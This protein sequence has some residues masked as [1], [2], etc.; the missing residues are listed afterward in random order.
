MLKFLLSCFMPFLSNSMY[1]TFV[2]HLMQFSSVND[3]KKST[4]STTTDLVAAEKESDRGSLVPYPLGHTAKV[5]FWR[6]TT[7]LVKHMLQRILFFSQRK[8]DFL[9]E[10]LQVFHFLCNID[11]AKPPAIN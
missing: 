10:L 1:S 9:F 8:D 6:L 11:S 4:S 3:K 5:G 7:H 2:N